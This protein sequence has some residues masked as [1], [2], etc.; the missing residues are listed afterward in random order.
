MCLYARKSELL[1]QVEVNKFIWERYMGK[2]ID[3]LTVDIF[4]VIFNTKQLIVIFLQYKIFLNRYSL[5]DCT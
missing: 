4:I 1:C 2:L 5:P 3:L